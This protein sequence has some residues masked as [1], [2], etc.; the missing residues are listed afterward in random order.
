MK[1]TK[2]DKMFLK[3]KG[4]KIMASDKETWVD[5]NGFSLKIKDNKIVAWSP[6]TY[7][8]HFG[9]TSIKKTIKIIKEHKIQ[10]NDAKNELQKLLDTPL[11]EKKKYICEHLEELEDEEI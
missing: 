9:Y 2:I 5:C 11:G 4:V 10:F 7:V 3:L 1:L 8:V 6:N